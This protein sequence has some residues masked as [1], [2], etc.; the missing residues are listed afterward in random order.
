MT[1]VKLRPALRAFAEAMEEKLRRH[2]G[3][4]THWQQQPIE[5]LVKLLLLEIEEFKVA[6]EFF[7]VAEAR[8]ELVDIANYAMIVADRL[9]L[10][11]QDRNRHAQPK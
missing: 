10:E 1:C 5:A 6:D 9:S 2:D 7:T 11:D 4:K 8:S 3:K